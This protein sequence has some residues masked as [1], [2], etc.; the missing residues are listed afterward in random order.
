MFGEWV[1]EQDKLESAGCMAGGN[2]RGWLK[3]EGG[4]REGKGE[5]GLSLKKDVLCP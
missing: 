1:L 2:S 3:Q 5:G 4:V